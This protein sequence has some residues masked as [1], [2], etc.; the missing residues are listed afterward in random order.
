VIDGGD[1]SVDPICVGL[2]E[3][4]RPECGWGSPSTY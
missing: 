3:G 2:W 4:E 1:D